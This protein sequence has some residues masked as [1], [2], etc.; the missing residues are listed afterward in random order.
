MAR[1]DEAFNA[2][3]SDP[4]P[5]SAWALQVAMV[6]HQQEMKQGM[7]NQEEQPK[8]K[9]VSTRKLS[10]TK[11]R[12]Y[13]EK[14]AEIIDVFTGLG[15]TVKAW[16]S[17][18]DIESWIFTDKDG[19]KGWLYLDSDDFTMGATKG[20]QGVFEGFDDKAQFVGFLSDN[21]IDLSELEE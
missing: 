10:S 14:L 5:A 11:G 8:P 16:Q 18:D 9:K 20:L 17:R 6:E 15:C 13:T 4:T 12:L 19:N 2:F 21:G 7:A 3:K 1:L